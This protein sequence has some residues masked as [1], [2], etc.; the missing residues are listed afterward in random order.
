MYKILAYSTC[1]FFIISFL[2]F[3][4][5]RTVRKSTFDNRNIKI[6]KIWTSWNI[7]VNDIIN[8]SLFHLCCLINEKY[9]I[10]FLARKI[11]QIFAKLYPQKHEMFVGGAHIHKPEHCYTCFHLTSTVHQLIVWTRGAFT[12]LTSR[13]LKSQHFD[14]TIYTCAKT[15]EVS[16]NWNFASFWLVVRMCDHRL[17]CMHSCMHRMQCMRAEDI[18]TRF[19]ERA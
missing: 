15:R 17:Q 5:H 11:F 8:C 12:L 18:Y 3:F 19:K 6:L 1:P 2:I 16:W 9:R 13:F 4:L 14:P 7:F 10:H